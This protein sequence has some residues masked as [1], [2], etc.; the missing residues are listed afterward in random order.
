MQRLSPPEKSSVD[1]KFAQKNALRLE[2]LTRM[3]D[4]FHDKHG[5][6]GAR[7]RNQNLFIDSA[8]GSEANASATGSAAIN[9]QISSCLERTEEGAHA[10]GPS[11]ACPTHSNAEDIANRGGY[12]DCDGDDA[13]HRRCGTGNDT[14]ICAL[15]AIA[16]TAPHA[17]ETSIPTANSSTN[18]CRERPLFPSQSC[19]TKNA[20]NIQSEH[21]RG[22]DD[23][24]MSAATKP[25]AW[26]ACACCGGQGGKGHGKHCRHTFRRCGVCRVEEV[27]RVLFGAEQTNRR[28]ARRGNDSIGARAGHNGNKMSPQSDDD[29]ERLSPLRQGAEGDRVPDEEDEYEW[30]TDTEEEEDDVEFGCDACGTAIGVSDDRFHCETCG[31]FDLVSEWGAGKAY[32]VDVKAGSSKI[33]S[34]CESCG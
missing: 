9:S 28:S 6:P 2:M 12:R 10:A 1:A 15:P 27:R 33:R 18:T 21:V 5:R 29:V 8:A 13:K 3:I 34:S 17:P 19:P 31:D 20:D 25:A 11:T 32:K 7:K 26:V 14:S 16:A 22:K 30:V 4:D 24:A 23:H